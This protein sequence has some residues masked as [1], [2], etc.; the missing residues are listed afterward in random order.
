MPKLNQEKQEWLK[1][2]F[3][4][5]SKQELANKLNVCPLTI[6]KIL[7]RFGINKKY[8]KKKTFHRTRRQMDN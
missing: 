3:D 4:R 8:S 6:S 7:E 1:Q 2:N 5:Y